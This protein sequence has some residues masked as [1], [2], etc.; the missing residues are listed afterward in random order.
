MPMNSWR[1]QGLTAVIICLASACGEAKG[2]DSPRHSAG[3]PPYRATVAD[4]EQVHAATLA[5]LFAGEPKLLFVQR[6]TAGPEEFGVGSPRERFVSVHRS[7]LPQVTRTTEESFWTRNGQRGHVS[8]AV[9]G[10]HPLE[11]V[12]EEEVSAKVLDSPDGWRSFF[13]AHPSALGIIRL[14]R[15]GY[16]RDGSQAL[17]YVTKLCPL[18]GRGEYVLL[19]KTRDGWAASS[20]SMD[21]VS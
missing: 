21:W 7:E 11:W 19:V 14:S 15:P 20:R 12:S 2:S 9:A 10:A 4:D 8:E 18:C 16:S 3:D 5:A 6:E 13:A 1:V 17:V